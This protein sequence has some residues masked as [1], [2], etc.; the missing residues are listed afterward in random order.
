MGTKVMLILRLREFAEANPFQTQRQDALP[1]KIDAALLLVL[2][3]FTRRA[4]MP[5]QIQ[6]RWNLAGEAGRLVNNCCGLESRHDLIAELAHPISIPRLDDSQVFS[7]RACVHP[8]FRPP[9][10]NNIVQQMLPEPFG[11]SRPLD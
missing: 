8:L 4:S 9:M 2:Y 1:S 6:N 7:L 10:E 3:G 11:F 5:V